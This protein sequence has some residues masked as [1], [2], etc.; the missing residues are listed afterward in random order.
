MLSDHITLAAEQT[1]TL[2]INCNSLSRRLDRESNKT[3]SLENLLAKLTDNLKRTQ[4][5]LSVVQGKFES[6]DEEL[7][8]YRA[9]N[10][11]LEQRLTKLENQSAPNV[12]R[13]VATLK[14][15][16]RANE[17]KIKQLEKD[18]KEKNPFDGLEGLGFSPMSL[19]VGGMHVR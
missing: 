4:E 6:V 10:Q 11:Q 12:F 3:R 7:K 17:I 18:V 14:T 5:E 19:P 8:R 13:D 16:L 1:K 15:Q 2:E 9:N